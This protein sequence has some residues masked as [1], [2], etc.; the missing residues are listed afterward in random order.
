[1]AYYQHIGYGYDFVQK[2]FGLIDAVTV[3]EVNGFISAR[4]NED[5]RITSIVGKK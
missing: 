4:F 2:L 5:N 1:M 3:D